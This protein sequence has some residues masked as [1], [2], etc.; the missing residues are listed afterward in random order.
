MKHI[1]FLLLAFSAYTTFAQKMTVAVTP[2]T[3]KVFVESKPVKT[4]TVISLGTSTLGII[5]VNKGYVT[6]GYTFEQLAQKKV[7]SFAIDLEKVAPLSAD[8]VSKVIEFKKI[9]DATGKVEKPDRPGM[10]GIT[11][12]GTELNSG[13]FI[14]TI[15]ESFTNFG[16]QMDNTN[17]TFEDKTKPSADLAVAAELIYFSKDTRGDGFQVSIIVEWSV[18]SY[19]EKKII[20]KI[21]T[22]GYSDTAETQFN[23]ELASAFRDAVTGLLSN[24]E[25][26]KLAKK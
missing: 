14:K 26:Q 13:L 5:A 4:T 9:T 23:P 7:A 3:S 15:N 2:V 18:Y 19:S 24:A 1:A 21:Q 17:Q 8:Y 10:Y 20:K 16:Y 12:K 22:A 6:Q 11:V 25:F